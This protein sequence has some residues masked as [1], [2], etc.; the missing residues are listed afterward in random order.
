[1]SKLKK[2]IIGLVLL[3]ILIPVG[4]Y[5]YI[6]FKLKDATVES[7]YTSKL[8]DVK[9]VTNILL[10]GTDG[11]KGETAFRTD[12]M[13]ILT[14]DSNNKNIKL[15]SLAR[16]TYVDI[17]GK[18]KGK[19]NTAYF[20]GKESLLFETIENE[21]GIGVDKFAI[22]DFNSLMDIIYVLDGVEVD[23]SQNEISQLN[24]YTKECYEISDNPK[25]GQLQLITNTGKQTL[26][27]YQVEVDVSQNEISQLNKY[28]KE[29]YEISDNPKKGQLQLITNTGK[30][31]LNGYQALAYTRIRYNDSAINRDERQR[32]VIMAIV[33]KYKNTSLTKFPALIDSIIPYLTTNLNSKDIFGLASDAISILSSKPLSE[34]MIQ[35]EFPI[36]DGIHTKGGSYKNAGW[37]WLYDIN[38]TVVL[39]DFIYNNILPE[40]NEYLLDTSNVQLNY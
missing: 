38:S 5:G 2:I 32:E 33:E 16:D 6:N 24:K 40:D 25:K 13:I 9:G 14:I 31:T 18:G 28:T 19:L 22:V 12:S 21:F 37:V 8:E 4:T 34:A 20:W 35:A 39:K 1:M 27:G 26:N 3:L 11:R 15:T 30:Q 7:T 29:C 23:V 36:I 17:P 10:L